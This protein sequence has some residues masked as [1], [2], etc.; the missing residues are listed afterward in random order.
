MLEHDHSHENNVVLVDLGCSGILNRV[1][2]IAYFK[3]EQNILNWL[4]Q[5]IQGKS[6]WPKDILKVVV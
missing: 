3:F 4:P 1:E 2:G 5:T 6:D